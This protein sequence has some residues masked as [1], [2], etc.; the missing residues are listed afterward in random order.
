MLNVGLTG[1]IASGKSTVARMLAGKGALLIDLDE[2]AHAVQEPQG[3]VWREIVRHFGPDVLCV[4]GKINRNK[5]GKCVFADR[6]KLDLLNSIVHPAVFEKWRRRMDEIRKTQPVAIVLSDIPLLI[7]AG[8][9]PM[10]D[11]VLLV[12]LSPEEQIARLTVRNGYSQEEAASRLA[13]Q[14]PIG[15]KLAYADIVI[16]NDGSPEETRRATAEVWEEL[17]K[18][19][20]RRREDVRL[21]P[22]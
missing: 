10:F 7:E 17:K 19:E 18:R 5:L 9:K 1:G 15:E 4:D 16:R 13:S 14:M 21:S 8:L 3:E 2:L 22:V 12:Y 11:L 6:K 20:R